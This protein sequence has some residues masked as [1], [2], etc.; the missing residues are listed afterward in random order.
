MCYQYRMSIELEAAELRIALEW[1]YA[2]LS[3][4]IEWADKYVAQSETP[5]INIIELA[6][7]KS[8]SEAI[9]KLNKLSKNLDMWSPIRLFFGRFLNVKMLNYPDA[10]KLA[11]NLYMLTVYSDDC[12]EDMTAFYS[13]WDSIDLA[14]DRQ[15]LKSLDDAITEFILDM[16][17]IA[18]TV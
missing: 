8:R 2:D 15:I 12:P 4:I 17:A 18:R 10:S 3:E 16:I 7:T 9:E 13:H 6:F 1:G 11:K 5:N 14:K